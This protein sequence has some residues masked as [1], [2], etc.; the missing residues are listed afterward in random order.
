[1]N[2]LVLGNG[3]DLAHG[4]PTKYTDFLN[5][6]EMTQRIYMWQG[7]YEEYVCKNLSDDKLNDSIKAILKEAMKGRELNRKRNEDGMWIDTYTTDNKYLD[8]FLSLIEKNTWI[9]YFIECFRNMGENWIDFELEI[10]KVIKT[11]DEGRKVL[12]KDGSI[13]GIGT[14]KSEILMR[15]I[16]KAKTTLQTAYKDERA[17]M[18]FVDSLYKDLEKLVRALEIYIDEFV[19]KNSVE[20]ISEEIRKL[21]VDHVL[22]FNYSDTYERLYIKEV[23]IEYDY[24]H[25]KADVNNTIETNNMVLGINEYLPRDRKD[26][27]LDFIAFKKFYQ[28]IYKGTGCKYKEWIEQIE[29]EY[30]EY[31]YRQ[32]KAYA[33]ELQYDADGN[34]NYIYQLQASLIKGEKCT[35]HNLYIFGHSL[36]VIDGD[37]LSELILHENMKTTIF[38]HK[39]YDKQGNHD[40]G[41]YDLSQKITNLVKIIGQDELIKRTGGSTKTIEFKLQQ[42]MVE[43]VSDT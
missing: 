30:M 42:D 6:C 5:F 29:K 21:N 13:M 3:F 38:Y 18:Q 2:I 36:D 41:K 23:E 8:E 17:I 12:E 10:S 11:L 34:K 27:E 20:I 24:I 16:K 9:G 4:L 43:G 1:M 31:L 26:K 37:I 40:N 14:Q 39:K 15:L 7:T 25:G 22:S 32:E 28:R 33:R 19:G 35:M